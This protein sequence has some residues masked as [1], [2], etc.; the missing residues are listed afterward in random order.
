[1]Q[2]TQKPGLKT[3]LVKSFQSD[4]SKLVTSKGV[5]E[6]APVNTIG[7]NLSN[8]SQMLSN[9]LQSGGLSSTQHTSA[10]SSLINMQSSALNSASNSSMSH[11]NLAGAVT[12][13]D[14]LLKHILTGSL[15]AKTEK[16]DTKPDGPVKVAEPVAIPK[17]KPVLPDGLPEAL[18]SK[19]TMLE[20]VCMYMC[21]MILNS[22]C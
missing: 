4:K 11:S 6:V 13:S 20:L 8:S 2:S 5:D 14:N 10:T 15:S 1:M 21:V 3:K 19:I 12:P 9:L 22:V 7:N 17:V 18:V 16:M